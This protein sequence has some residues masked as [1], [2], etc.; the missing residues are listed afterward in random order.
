MN[1]K[2]LFTCA[3]LISSLKHD[4]SNS[5]NKV[6]RIVFWPPTRGKLREVVNQVELA[7]EPE[8]MLVDLK[9]DPCAAQKAQILKDN[10]LLVDDISGRVMTITVKLKEQVSS[11]H[12]DLSTNHEVIH[13]IEDFS[14]IRHTWDQ[15]QV[16]PMNSFAWN[17]SWW[18]AFQTHGDLHLM[19]FERAG[20]VV[21]IAPLYLDRWHGLKRLRFLAT[22]DACTDYADIIC[23]PEHYNLCAWLLGEYIHAQR[24]DIVELEATRD[25]RLSV[26]L[27]ESLSQNYRFDHRIA[28]PTWRIELPDSWETFVA[29]VMKSVRRK[30]NKAT[31]RLA[32]EQ[33]SLHSTVSG[34]SLEEAFD[35]FK[36]LHTRHRNSIGKPSPD[37]SWGC[38]CFRISARYDALI[39][40]LIGSIATTNWPIFSQLQKQCNCSAQKLHENNLENGRIIKNKFFYLLFLN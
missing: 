3:S 10:G 4:V 40:C 34:L 2:D 36:S 26:I 32:S 9:S 27:K 24:F 17:L 38:C 30:I 25:D 28:E 5:Q 11:L 16:D 29:G 31:R 39:N 18:K 23:T 22:G 14:S 13:L 20:K 7:H 6:E 19:K 1:P 21:G 15:F 8:S 37:I 35:I 33:F 12:D